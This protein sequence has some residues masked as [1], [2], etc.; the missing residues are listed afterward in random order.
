MYVN[1]NEVVVYYSNWNEAVWSSLKLKT[2]FEVTQNWIKM[3]HLARIWI[4]LLL[5]GQSWISLLEFTQIFPIYVNIFNFTQFEWS[6]PNLLKFHLM[7]LKYTQM[8]F[9]LSKFE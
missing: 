6:S 7:L 5:F 8:I 9:I 3:F 1:L 4:E 2:L